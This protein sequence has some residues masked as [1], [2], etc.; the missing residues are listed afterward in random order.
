MEKEDLLF[1]IEFLE[2]I[3]AREP[4]NVEV[5]TLLGHDYTQA[6]LL[7][8]GLEMDL[9]LASLRPFEPIVHYNLACSLSLTGDTDG[10]VQALEKAIALGYTDHQH[11]LGD[12]DLAALRGDPRFAS[13]L[14]RLLRAVRRRAKARVSSEK[15]QGQ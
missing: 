7:P 13:L 3:R 6:G 8:Q 5:L 10:A 15:D 9:R 14:T 1:E 11:L 4:D 2:G 12:P